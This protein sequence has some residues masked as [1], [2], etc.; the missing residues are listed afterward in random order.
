MSLILGCDGAWSK[1]RE[2]MINLAK[3]KVIFNQKYIQHSYKEL[4][5]SPTKDGG[6]YALKPPYALH[7]WPKG[8]FMM[9]GLPN[10]N[11]SFTCTFF[12]PN[13]VLD[14]MENELDKC[15]KIEK[16]EAFFKENFPEIPKLCPDYV[17][18][19]I[20]NK[21]SR[22]FIGKLHS[23]YHIEDKKAPILLLGDAAHTMVPFYGQGMNCG[24][25]D[26]LELFETFQINN[27]QIEQTVSIFGEQRLPRG[28]AIQDLSLLNY[29]EMRSHTASK[30]FLFRKKMEGWLHN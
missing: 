14:S 20:T 26:A 8:D 6:D 19:F 30:L 28:Q 21:S 18:Q 23:W 7:I 17:D 16:I 27:Y 24:L 5:L 22:L 11:R 29:L 12:C 9:I 2:N 4:H 3:K 25:E 1:V 10:P 15:L 13:D